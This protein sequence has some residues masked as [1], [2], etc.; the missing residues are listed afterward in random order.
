M[1]TSSYDIAY[2]TLERIV[3]QERSGNAMERAS[4]R[5]AEDLRSLETALRGQVDDALVARTREG[6]T[7]AADLLEQS[8][9][10]VGGIV[11]ATRTEALEGATAG[12]ALQGQ[13]GSSVIDV[14][15]AVRR[16][17]GQILDPSMLRDIVAHEREHERQASVWN[18]QVVS[19]GDGRMLD[20][21]TVSEVGAMSVQSSIQWVSADYGRMF[22]SVTSLGVTPDEALSAARS[23]DLEGLGQEIRERRGIGED[24]QE[25]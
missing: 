1:E 24:A 10:L 18:A 25:M 11:G 14:A 5:A 21:E 7:G 15:S 8:G 2:G 23:G 22:H 3:G 19:I 13:M 4:V 9:H 6:L 20:R 17:S 16:E 12:T